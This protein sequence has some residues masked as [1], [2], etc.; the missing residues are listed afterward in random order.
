MGSPKTGHLHNLMLG[1]NI[2][3][4]T[5]LGNSEDWNKG[6]AAGAHH[7][8]SELSTMALRYEA[9]V[10][11]VEGILKSQQTELS[12]FSEGYISPDMLENLLV[13]FKKEVG[14]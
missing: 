6:W 1:A 5:H 10:A 14:L 2:P 13:E 3:V 7:A 4:P 8:K 11:R 12:A 9:Y